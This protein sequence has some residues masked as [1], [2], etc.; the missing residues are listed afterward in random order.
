LIAFTFVLV[1]AKLN[2]FSVSPDEPA[3]SASNLVVFPVA[4][5]KRV[6]P[7]GR[8]FQLPAKPVHKSKRLS[9]VNKLTQQPAV[10]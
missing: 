4:A 1:R 10:D 5:L 3:S 9:A 2:P 8:D 7:P 6:P